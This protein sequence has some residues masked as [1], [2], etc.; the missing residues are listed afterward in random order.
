MPAAARVLDMKAHKHH[1]PLRVPMLA[2]KLK[3]YLEDLPAPRRKTIPPPESRVVVKKQGKKLVKAAKAL[4]SPKN[5]SSMKATGIKTE[6]RVITPELAKKWLAHNAEKNR[7]VSR[8]TVEAYAREMKAGRWQVTH[9]SIAFNEK[10]ELIDGQHR[11]TAIVEAD[12]SVKMPVT[13]GLPLE[14]NAPID[15]GYGRRIDQIIGKAPR[16]VSALR[17]MYYLEVGQLG[18]SFKTQIGLV[19]ELESRHGF[20]VERVMALDKPLE[21]GI[22]IPA[23]FISMC[24]FAYPVNPTKVLEFVEQVAQGELLTRGMPAHTF[25]RWLMQDNHRTTTQKL[26]A[27]ANA[28]RSLLTG[29][30][31]ERITAG[32]GEDHLGL[33]G[34]LYL[35]QKR[36]VMKLPGTPTHEE[37]SFI[38][39]AKK[40]EKKREA[41]KNKAAE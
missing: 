35:C 24:A 23:G 6:I 41:K 12:V 5:V 15:Q 31:L 22:K 16:Y 14:F 20:A 25:R 18:K 36:R 10:G 38:S 8:R 39:M 37:A 19:E 9:Q 34:Y 1:K 40:G 7:T 11:L 29:E 26:I 17:G 33:G 30:E 27:S 32:G 13:T 2:D 21:G 4:V 28:L 3:N